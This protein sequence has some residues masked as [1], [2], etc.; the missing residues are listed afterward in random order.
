MRERSRMVVLLV[1]VANV[2]AAPAAAQSGQPSNVRDARETA[3]M[4]RRSYNLGRWQEAIDGF[5][6]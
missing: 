4:A 1:I 3:E 5:E 6:R 2:V